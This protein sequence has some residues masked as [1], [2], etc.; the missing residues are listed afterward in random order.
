MDCLSCHVMHGQ[1]GVDPANWRDDQLTVAA[2]GNNACTQCHER[3][4]DA[5]ALAAHTHHGSRVDR[6]QLLQ[7]AT[8]ATRRSGS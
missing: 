2:R 8:W 5:K 4:R 6:Q 7:T 1:P 3:L